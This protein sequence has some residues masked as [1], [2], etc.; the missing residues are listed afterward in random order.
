MNELTA[1]D[2]I[3]L[4]RLM[5]DLPWRELTAQ[6]HMGFA[7]AGENARIC[8]M[9]AARSGAFCE[10]LDIRS[11][12]PLLAIIGGDG[13]QVEFHGVDEDGEPLCFAL[14]LRLVQY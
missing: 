3:E 11:T 9:S 2:A 8:E 14:P 13:L 5:G 6:D 12:Y 10:L 4:F 7:D 1:L